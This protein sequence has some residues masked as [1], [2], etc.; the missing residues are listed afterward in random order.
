MHRCACTHQ[1]GSCAVLYAV[2]FRCCLGLGLWA[3]Q[4]QDPGRIVLLVT[5]TGVAAAATGCPAQRSPGSEGTGP[6]RMFLK[7]ALGY[8][9]AQATDHMPGRWPA[10]L[11]RAG[12]SQRPDQLP[13]A[14]KR[15]AGHV[16]CPFP[17]G[18][19]RC[20][21]FSGVKL[22]NP[23]VP[24]PGG[25]VWPG[26]GAHA[27]QIEAAGHRAAAG[28]VYNSGEGVPDLERSS[29]PLGLASCKERSL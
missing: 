21:G 19:G 28:P 17:G 24:C 9:L 12:A 27:G 23:G 4:D 11:Q 2:G 7:A 25:P 15:G 1:A 29:S 8:S 14:G 22:F 26:A 5:S 16:G 18:D 6:G 20:L 10:G 3:L 13:R